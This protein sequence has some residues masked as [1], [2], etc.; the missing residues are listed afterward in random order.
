M[1]FVPLCLIV[2]GDLNRHV[3]EERCRRMAV[4]FRW[5]SVVA[6]GVEALPADDA[7]VVRYKVR[8]GHHRRRTLCLIYGEASWEPVPIVEL[9]PATTAGMA[10]TVLDINNNHTRWTV[11][12]TQGWPCRQMSPRRR[13]WRRSWLGTA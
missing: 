6:L 1:R 3:D 5:R 2:P 7:G 10:R 11:T 13:L 12:A 4:E 8:E 9:A